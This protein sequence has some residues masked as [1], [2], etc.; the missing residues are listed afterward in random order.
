M[1]TV[2]IKFLTGFA[3]KKFCAAPLSEQDLLKFISTELLTI[4][5][6]TFLIQRS[7]GTWVSQPSAVSKI[8]SI[9]IEKGLVICQAT[10]EL[11]PSGR[12][13]IGYRK[14]F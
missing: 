9:L 11:Y 6:I 3:K 13:I 10:G 14:A 2:F 7:T 1:L 5:E 8:L 12:E 4:N